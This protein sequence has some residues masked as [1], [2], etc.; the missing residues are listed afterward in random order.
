MH[1]LRNETIKHATEATVPFGPEL[2]RTEWSRC[3]SDFPHS[4]MEIEHPRVVEVS[5]VTAPMLH[6]NFKL[7]SGPELIDVY[8]RKMNE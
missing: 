8:P 3:F 1:V 4:K 7:Q 5:T 6:F 2:Y